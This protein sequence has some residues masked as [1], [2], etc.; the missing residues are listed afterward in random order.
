MRRVR[1]NTAYLRT[2]LLYLQWFSALRFRYSLG[3]TVLACQHELEFEHEHEENMPRNR[4]AAC[5]GE[6]LGG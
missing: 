5:V 1:R 2:N 3:C 6:S 4:E